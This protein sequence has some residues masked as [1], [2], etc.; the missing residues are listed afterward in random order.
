MK[1][2]RQPCVV[3]APGIGASLAISRSRWR[4]SMYVLS[5]MV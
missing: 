1:K 2:S 4:S 5:A 3:D